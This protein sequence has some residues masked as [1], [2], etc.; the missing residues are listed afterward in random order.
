MKLLTI[1][2]ALVLTACG[3]AEDQDFEKPVIRGYFGDQYERTKTHLADR[4]FT[5]EKALDKA[6][7]SEDE[8]REYLTDR[9]FTG[10]DID[11]GFT[12]NKE[13]A[14]D[15]AGAARD[16]ASKYLYE[17]GIQE[18]RHGDQATQD[19]LRSL[20]EQSDA[21]AETDAAHYAILEALKAEV[22][23]LRKQSVEADAQLMAADAEL[24][25]TLEAEVAAQVADLT[26]Q[27]EEE[28]AARAAA[29]EAL[30]GKITAEVEAIAQTIEDLEDELEAQIEDLEQ[31]VKRKARRIVRK[32]RSLQR[33]QYYTSRS[34]SRLNSRV[35]RLEQTQQQVTVQRQYVGYSCT[36]V[37]NGMYAKKS[38]SK[39][40]LYTSRYCSGRYTYVDTRHS[41][42]KNN[43]MYFYSSSSILGRMTVGGGR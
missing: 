3:V 32:I 33:S 27:I 11:N 42:W 18:I 20:Q 29:V 39:I 5:Q 8:T 35:S 12:V 37:G 31:K 10:E 15:D 21:Q 38:Y 41:V 26:S 43:T 25:A 7:E 36:Y 2:A 6:A 14:G 22:D 1:T 34:L 28:E 17:R 4:G 24:K 16:R 19:K 30:D 9:N 23:E 13:A 40:K